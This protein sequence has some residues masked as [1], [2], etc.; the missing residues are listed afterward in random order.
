[1]IKGNGQAV[2]RPFT[3]N[4]AVASSFLIDGVGFTHMGEHPAPLKTEVEA[5]EK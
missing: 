4:E 3:A 2:M 5:R 1:V